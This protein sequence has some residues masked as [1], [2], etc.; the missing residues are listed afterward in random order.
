[1]WILSLV[2]WHCASRVASQNFMF[3]AQLQLCL[4]V[5]TIVLL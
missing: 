1:V 5:I 2:V 3:V 4:A